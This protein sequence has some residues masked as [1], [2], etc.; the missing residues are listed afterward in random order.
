MSTGVDNRSFSQWVFD[1][2]VEQGAIR[3][4]SKTPPG[5]GRQPSGNLS[6]QQARIAE[7]KNSPDP[8]L[9]LWGLLGSALISDG[10]GRR[11]VSQYGDY[12]AKYC[13]GDPNIVVSVMKKA[14]TGVCAEYKARYVK[15]SQSQ[16]T[17]D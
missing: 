6:I 15:A 12:A 3:D 5:R 9:V 4:Y 13:P 17:F 2:L 7:L 14:A 8:N 11:L 16:A 1:S 10:I